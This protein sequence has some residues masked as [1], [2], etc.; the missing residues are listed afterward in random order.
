MTAHWD[1]EDPAAVEGE[2]QGEAF[3]GA[4][5]YFKRRIELFLMLPKRTI[6]E[7]AMR[8]KLAEIGREEG[9]STKARDRQ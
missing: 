5:A 4:L 8:S 1:V 9:A 3:I 2:V 6:D 7:M